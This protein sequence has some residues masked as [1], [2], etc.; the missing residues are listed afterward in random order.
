MQGSRKHRHLEV[1]TLCTKMLIY[2]AVALHILLNN[3]YTEGV[4]AGPFQTADECVLY[5]AS[6]IERFAKEPNVAL[7]CVV[8]KVKGA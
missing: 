4:V 5:V 7:G 8:M 1:N 6:R 3:P 2:Y